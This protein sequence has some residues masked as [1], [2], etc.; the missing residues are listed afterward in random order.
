MVDSTDRV[1][2]IGGVRNK[3]SQ[4]FLLV[5]QP[6]WLRRITGDGDRETS[7]KTRTLL[8][9]SVATALMI[10]LAGG[11]LLLQL[12]GQDDIAAPSAVGDP[13]EVGDL[14]ITVVSASDLGDRFAIDV[15]VSGVDDDL[16]GITLIT[17]DQTLAPLAS[18]ADG[19]CSELTVQ[20]QRCRLDFDISAVAATNR[21]LLV[22]RGDAQ[23][24]WPLAS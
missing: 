24:N 9:L 4:R 8:M 12:S 20:A 15:E 2:E 10:L 7:V 17:G 21:T 16:S 14:D 23:Q 13:V 18:P 11:V 6:L 1:V 5:A 19:R 3:V 22:V